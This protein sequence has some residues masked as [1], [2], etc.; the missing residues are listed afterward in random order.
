MFMYKSIYWWSLFAASVYLSP[1][2]VQ[3]LWLNASVMQDCSLRQMINK[4]TK[5]VKKRETERKGE[6]EL[7]MNWR[8]ISVPTQTGKLASEINS[9]WPL[10][11]AA[12]CQVIFQ[13]KWQVKNNN[14][15]HQDC[16]LFSALRIVWQFMSTT[17]LTKEHQKTPLRRICLQ[18]NNSLNIIFRNHIRYVS[19]NKLRC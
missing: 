14:T 10:D 7:W 1:F 17:G 6:R 4:I 13:G 19:V 11:D 8:L 16:A 2:S 9:H 18:I 5:N 15:K 12:D 3:V